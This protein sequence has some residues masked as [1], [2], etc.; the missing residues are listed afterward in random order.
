MLNIKEVV[1]EM[2]LAAQTAAKEYADARYEGKDG[3]AC[4]FAWVEIYPANKGNTKLGKAERLMLHD[5]G[6]R[7]DWTGRAYQVWDPAKWP[8][9]SI[10]VKEV[11]AMAAASVLKKYGFKAYAASRL[12]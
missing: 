11:G 9:Q 2:T 7:P 12:D 6:F 5:M 1:T 3:G 10:D 8:G 4:G